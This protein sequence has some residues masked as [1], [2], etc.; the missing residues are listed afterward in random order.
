MTNPNDKT[1]EELIAE[2]EL[3]SSKPLDP[4]YDYTPVF[5][6][7]MLVGTKQDIIDGKID[8]TDRSAWR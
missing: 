3:E 2:L 4:N 7:G 5:W 1:I 8:P 6:N